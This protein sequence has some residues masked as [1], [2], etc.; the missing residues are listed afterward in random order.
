MKF[1][2]EILNL[3]QNALQRMDMYFGG[4]LNVEESSKLGSRGLMLQERTALKI[5]EPY[6]KHYENGFKSLCKKFSRA[7]FV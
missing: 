3:D 6:F 7:A 5:N 2:V 4:V 1:P